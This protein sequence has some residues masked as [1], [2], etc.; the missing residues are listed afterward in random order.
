[1]NLVADKVGATLSGLCIVHC[2]F[3]PLLTGILPL[4]S[5]F[6]EAEWFHYLI[7]VLATVPAYILVKD[8]FSSGHRSIAL[9]AITGMVLLIAAVSVHELHDYETPITVLGGLLLGTAHLR[10]WFLH[11]RCDMT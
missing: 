11:R 2:L 8:M 9:Q 1:M 7:I 5:V 4:L 3:L 10:R 6:T